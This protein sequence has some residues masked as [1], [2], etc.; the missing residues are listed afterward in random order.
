MRAVSAAMF[1]AT[2]ATQDAAASVLAITAIIG[3][4]TGSMWTV[5]PLFYAGF[6]SFAL[7]AAGSIRD[8]ATV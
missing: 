1:V 6:T 4:S 8:I 2:A 3:T 7:D 5:Q